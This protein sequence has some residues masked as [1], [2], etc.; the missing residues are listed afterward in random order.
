MKDY[1]T[2]ERLGVIL[3]AHFDEIIP[4]RKVDRYR[5]DFYIPGIDTYVEFDGYAHFTQNTTQIRDEDKN[6]I[7]ESNMST[8][9]RIPYFVQLTPQMFKHYFDI[10]MLL[11]CEYDYPQGFIDK[12]ALLPADFNRFGMTLYKDI[13]SNL[14][15]NVRVEIMKTDRENYRH[16]NENSTTQLFWEEYNRLGGAL[17]QFDDYWY[18]I[19]LF[20]KLTGSKVGGDT[21]MSYNAGFDMFEKCIVTCS[22]ELG[23]STVKSKKEAD[24]FFQSIDNVHCYS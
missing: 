7:I 16:L 19:E 10:D 24:I 12:K 11:E 22:D 14:P 3:N 15:K 18:F 4:Q 17:T 6:E 1:L 9:I 20:Y 8:I 21:P 2:E 23:L 13:L 5:A